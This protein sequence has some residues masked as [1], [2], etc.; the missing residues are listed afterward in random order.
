MLHLYIEHECI[1]VLTQRMR[2]IPDTWR[3]T[4]QEHAL[5]IASS[6]WRAPA[7]TMAT[8]SGPPSVQA[9]SSALAVAIA[10][11]VGGANNQ[12]SNASLAPPQAAPTVQH[13]P[14]PSTSGSAEGQRSRYVPI[15]SCYIIDN[16]APELYYL[17]LYL[18]TQCF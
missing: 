8:G 18:C 5:S 16:R 6:A 1:A 14:Q 9:L 4:A 17:W 12:S 2:T 3:A 11:H 10:Q 13:A 7:G 15:G